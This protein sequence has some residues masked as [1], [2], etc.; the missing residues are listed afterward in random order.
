MSA[1][2]LDAL[3]WRSMTAAI[4]KIKAPQSFLK[5]LLFGNEETLSTEDIELSYLTGARDMAPFVRKNG[6]ALMVEGLGETF[7]TVQTPNIRIKRPMKPS[8][9]LFTRRAGTTVFP[10]PGGQRAAINSYIARELKRLRDLVA[11]AEEWMVSQAIRGE[12]DYEVD[13]E[14]NF[15]ITYPRTSTHSFSVGTDWDDSDSNPEKDVLKAKR[16][17]SDD[18]GL[19]PTHMI[20][21]QTAAEAFMANSRVSTLLDT[22]N[23][24][25]GGLTINSQFN[26]QGAIY[27][28]RFAGL[29]VWEYSRSVNKDGTATELVRD[30]YAEIVC[31]VPAAEN[32]MYYGAIP[33]LPVLKGRLLQAKLFAKSWDQED[34]AVRY[35]LVHSRPLPVPRLPDSTVSMQVDS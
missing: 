9:L 11:N 29:Q 5:R 31:A 21:G 18:V 6:E 32:V 12:I 20:L 2:S 13:P 34:P 25:A 7:A 10:T 4:N 35:A 23:Y 8:D 24:E 26:E 30:K 28:G 16:L 15:T 3:K 22:R 17:I 27:L 14:E 33:D 19:S 1:Y